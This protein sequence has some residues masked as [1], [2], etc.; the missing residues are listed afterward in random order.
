MFFL[1][2]LYRDNQ[3]YLKNRSTIEKFIFYRRNNDDID[4]DV[5]KQNIENYI[6]TNPCISDAAKIVE[7]ASYNKSKKK[8]QIV[9]GKNV[10]RGETLINCMQIL[11]QIVNFDDEDTQIRSG[12]YDEILNGIKKSSILAGNERMCLLLNS[13]IEECYSEGN[14]FAIPFIS[15]YSLNIAKGKLKQKGY[16]CCMF[17]SADTYFNVCFNYY[18]KGEV[19]C[20]LIKYIDGHYDIWKNRYINHWSLFVEDNLFQDFVDDKYIPIQMWKMDTGDIKKDLEDYFERTIF[21]LSERRKRIVSKCQKEKVG[22][23]SQLSLKDS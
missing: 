11:L 18:T 16:Q 4:I 13:F 21:S 15:G 22:A 8:Y 7:Q 23:N 19:S 6:V 17:D 2:E 10:F 1:D 3:D 5:C 14:F 9:D 20:Q 12:D